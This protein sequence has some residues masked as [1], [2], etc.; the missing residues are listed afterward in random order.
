MPQP[1]LDFWF[2]FAST[3]SFL[4]AKRIDGI[5]ADDGVAVRWRPFLLG[6]IFK[7]QG[8]TTSPFNLY[9]AKGR[10]MVRDISRIAATRGYHFVMP[11]PFPQPSLTAARVALAVPE[12]SRP[13]LCR[14][15]FE[16][17]FEHGA[18]IDDLPMLSMKIA[19]LGLDAASVLAAADSDAVKARLRAE[20]SAAQALGIFGAPTF[21]T[22]DGELFWG[23]DRLR[24]AVR[25][26]AIV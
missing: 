5:A 16:A 2:D 6:P 14:A 17:E 25:H 1:T 23:D 7:A 10:Y 8:W 11:D 20:T 21:V 18:R 19:A 24:H 22:A 3:Y 13:A 12:S 4:T 15:I 26:A 9:P